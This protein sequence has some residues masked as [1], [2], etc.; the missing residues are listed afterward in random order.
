MV[1]SSYRTISGLSASA[2]Q[3]DSLLHA[4]GQL[5]RFLAGDGERQPDILQPIVND[6]PDLRFSHVRVLSQAE[7]DV[8]K[9]GEA[10]EQGCTLK[11]IPETESVSVDFRLASLR[12]RSSKPVHVAIGRIEHAD[13]QLQQDTLAAARLA[14]HRQ[15]FTSL[16]RH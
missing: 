15:R 16:H 8:L 9:H 14:D 5:C 11:Q 1:G 10:V 12:E 7:G 13:D 3:S 4:S 6:L 2:S